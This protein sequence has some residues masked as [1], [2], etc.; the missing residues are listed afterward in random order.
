MDKFTYLTGGL[1]LEAANKVLILL[2]GR[3]GSASDML[4]FIKG[5]K[6]GEF[7]II[8]PQAINNSWYP[9]SFLE[10]QKNDSS[11][12]LA[13]VYLDQIIMELESSGFKKSQF[14]FL[15]FS[16]GAC[17]TLEYTTRNA[18][19]YG[20]IIAFTGG[21]IGNTIMKA[22]YN[23]NFDATPV[24]IGSSDPDIHV[25]VERVK[26]SAKLMTLMGANVNTIIYQNMGHTIN[27]DEIMHCNAILANDRTINNSEKIDN[28]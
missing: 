16:Q 4:N 7:A 6:A 23:G 24:F 8:A 3:G 5:F 25:P 17:L 20:G 15:G 11:L 18:A 12:N 22:R 14:Y 1:S 9:Y 28:K 2:H 13:L 10:A 27:E 19:K 26:N 21:L